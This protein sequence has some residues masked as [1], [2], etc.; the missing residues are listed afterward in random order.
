[1]RLLRLLV[2]VVVF[3]LASP[4]A[5]AVQ[6]DEDWRMFGNALALV[7]HFVRLAAQSPDPAVVRK[8]VD[9]MLAGRNPEANRAAGEMMDEVLRDMPQEQRA[10]FVSVARDILAI[11]R[12]D[13]AAEAAR[14]AAAAPL[15]RALQARKDLHA[16]G[17]RYWDERQFLEAVRRG[18]RIAVDLYLAAQGL[19]RNPPAG[20]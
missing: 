6:D 14:E 8:G 3:A 11:A 18:D 4:G 10:A 20:R 13:G 7:Q 15:E 5:R 9:D 16:M 1:M 2:P 19:A 17:L 12:R